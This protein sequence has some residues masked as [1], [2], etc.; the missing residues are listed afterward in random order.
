M[1]RRKNRALAALL[2][3]LALIGLLAARA[4][5]DDKSASGTPLDGA[6]APA[7]AY[8]LVSTATQ[9]GWLPLPEEGELSFPL[10]Q[11][12]P[13]GSEAVNVIHLTPD[14]VYMEDSTC[15]N[16]DCVNQGLVTL[17]NREERILSNMII[18]LP[19]Q[20]WLQLLTPEE[21][22]EMVRDSE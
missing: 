8:V 1:R 13:D 4:E 3:V 14:G 9:T 17:E 22:L 15:E 20:V 2:A 6:P 21:I 18:C 12:L 5:T 16:H 10:K 7:K 11:T 19:N